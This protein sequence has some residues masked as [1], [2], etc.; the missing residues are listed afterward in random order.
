MRRG[1]RREAVKGA[2]PDDLGLLQGAGSFDI[3]SRRAREASLPWVWPKWT[4]GDL[5]M[6]ELML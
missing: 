4:G 6:G 3:S 2:L 1:Q 5:G